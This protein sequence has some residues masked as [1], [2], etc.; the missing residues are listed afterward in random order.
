[1]SIEISLKIGPTEFS[2]LRKLFMGHT[3]WFCVLFIFL[4]L[5]TVMIL[6]FVSRNLNSKGHLEPIE[7]FFLRKHYIAP[8]IVLA[9]F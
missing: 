3:G 5:S 4:I 6:G 7:L 1:M 9:Y 2:I 8:G